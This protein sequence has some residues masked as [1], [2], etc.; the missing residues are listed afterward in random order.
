MWHC[1][2][3]NLW[4]IYYQS[5]RLTLSDLGVFETT[6]TIASD[7]R[8][9]AEAC[10]TITQ[11]LDLGTWEL[12]HIIGWRSRTM[13]P[14]PKPTPKPTITRKITEDDENGGSDDVGEHTS[15]QSLLARIGRKLGCRIWIASNDHKK[16]AEGGCL[17]DLS[18][19]EL[20][21]LGLDQ[22]SMAQIR[23]IDVLWIYK[24]NQVAAAFEIEC[25]TAVYS[26]ILRMS[27]LVALAPNLNFPLYIVAPEKRMAKVEREL[28]RPTFSQ[29]ELTDRCGFFSIER[30]HENADQM[31]RWA[32]EPSAIKSLAK[33]VKQ[34]N[35]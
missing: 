31:L 13:D 21:P 29:L 26:G 11:K 35:T 19:P 18:L 7:Y 8:L 34:P 16:P 17:G 27:D 12:E 9:F 3:H 1:H 28:S 2:N 5:V 32:T 4:P 22:D 30:L 24:G 33:Y 25:T 14:D 10:L 20:P 23:L 15:V 6:G